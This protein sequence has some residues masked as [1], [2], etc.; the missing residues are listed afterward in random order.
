[1]Q[2]DNPYYNARVKYYPNG[3]QKITVFN[4]GVFNPDGWERIRKEDEEEKDRREYDLTNPREDNVKRAKDKIFDIAFMNDWE[5]MVTLTLDPKQIDRYDA[6]EINKRVGKW[7]KNQVQRKDLRYLIVPEY[8]EDGAI[9]FHG[10]FKGN[11]TYLDAHRVDKQGRKVWNIKDW[12]FGW[13][14]AVRLDDNR[15]RVAKYI[16]KYITKCTTKIMG[17]FYYAGGGITRE[18]P[19]DYAHVDY[20]AVEGTEYEIPQAGMRVKYIVVGEL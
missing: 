10:F 8:H 18:V 11:M 1:M 7:L 19:S 12:R 4:R 9:H 14:T 20:D 16:T 17:K 2:R 3:T 6:K 15:I 13:S 5:Y